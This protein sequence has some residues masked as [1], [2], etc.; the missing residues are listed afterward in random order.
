MHGLTCRYNCKL[1]SGQ[2]DCSR[3][4]ILV[5]HRYLCLLS[6]AGTKERLLCTRVQGRDEEYCTQMIFTGFRSASGM[7]ARPSQWAINLDLGD[8][9]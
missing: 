5:L 9:K 1:G 2:G 6:S 4:C 3:L 8:A 7:S